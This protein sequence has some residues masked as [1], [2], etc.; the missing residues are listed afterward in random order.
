[1]LTMSFHRSPLPGPPEQADERYKFIDIDG[2]RYKV[3]RSGHV[4]VLIQGTGKRA[5]Y[6]RS[7]THNSIIAARVRFA[8]GWFA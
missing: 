2:R 6:T 1:M 5:G 7:L 4:S 8:S 3:Y